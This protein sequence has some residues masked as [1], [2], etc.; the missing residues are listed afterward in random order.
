[1][2]KHPRGEGS[3]ELMLIRDVVDH[4]AAVHQGIRSLKWRQRARDDLVL[5][6]GSLRMIHLKLDTAGLQ[7]ICDLFEDDGSGAAC[8][9]RCRGGPIVDADRFGLR[10]C[11]LQ[12][13][14]FDFESSQ[15]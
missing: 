2:L 15:E 4:F 12:E 13:D 6:R 14:E 10:K 1:M 7:C 3:P 5:S 9:D 8:V 11:G